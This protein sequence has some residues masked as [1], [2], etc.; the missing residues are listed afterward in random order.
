[1]SAPVVVCPTCGADV[2]IALPGSATVP[3]NGRAVFQWHN[4]GRDPLGVNAGPC[5][6]SRQ[7]VPDALLPEEVDVQPRPR[8]FGETD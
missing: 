1:M 2:K 4:N 5:A 6:M 3:R 7:A 8:A